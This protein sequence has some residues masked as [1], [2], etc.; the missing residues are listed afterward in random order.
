LMNPDRREWIAALAGT[1]TI[2]QVAALLRAIGETLQHI[3]R[4]VNV[5]LAL[6]VLLLK[7][8]RLPSA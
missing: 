8:P 6:D 4:N 5:R 1:F 3:D 7:L 2:A